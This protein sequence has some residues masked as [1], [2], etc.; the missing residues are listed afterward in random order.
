MKIHWSEDA[1]NDL[2]NLQIYITANNPEAAQEIV[3]RILMT[4]EFLAR[5][6]NLG[7]PGRVPETRELVVGKTP[8][9][10]PY[11]AE[12]NT[13]EILRVYHHSRRWPDHF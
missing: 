8:V 12:E 7:K 5:Q 2:D 1:L 4:I 13:L 6:P 9:I 3:E 11:R 10:I